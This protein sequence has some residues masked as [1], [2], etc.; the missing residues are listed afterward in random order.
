ML[1][2]TNAP[3]MELAKNLEVATEPPTKGA[4]A[5]G[6]RKPKDADR[7]AFG[8]ARDDD[9][10]ALKAKFLEVQ[11]LEWAL[12]QMEDLKE[13]A[14][15]ANDGGRATTGAFMKTYQDKLDRLH[16]SI[17]NHFAQLQ[18][19]REVAN[20]TAQLRKN[21]NEAIKAANDARKAQAKAAREAAQAERRAVK[22][23]MEAERDDERAKAPKT[24]AAEL[25]EKAKDKTM[26]VAAEMI[27]ALPDT[28]ES[29]RDERLQ[30]Q[31]DALNQ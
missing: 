7:T 22:R 23:T 5:P 11:G 27:D 21:A 31:I 12:Q 15:A 19:K 4:G 26:R 17:D 20:E 16:G 6:S 18:A 1:S 30:A 14:A 3:T 8:G 24:D 28:N 25:A 9:S 2:T 13:S 29:N 10:L